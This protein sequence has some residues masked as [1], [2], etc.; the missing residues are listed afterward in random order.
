VISLGAFSFSPSG[1][2]DGTDITYVLSGDLESFFTF[3][4]SV[5]SLTVSTTDPANIGTY[6][7]TLTGSAT[8]DTQT[9]S[10][11]FTVTIHNE[12]YG[13]SIDTSSS[14]V[15]TIN[16]NLEGSSKVT[17]ITD[18]STSGY[19]TVIHYVL[20]YQNGSAIDTNIL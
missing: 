13:Q 20:T 1:E 11:T 4:A 18:F 10:T 7:F 6:S 3:D 15:S 8:G 16:Y 19:C 2:C 17:Y 9:D 5:P 12:C 14:A